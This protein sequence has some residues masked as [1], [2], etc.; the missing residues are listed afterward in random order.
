MGEMIGIRRV[1]DVSVKNVTAEQ[2]AE[3]RTKQGA[4]I[5][6]G[7]ERLE[8][9][10]CKADISFALEGK[11]YAIDVTVSDPLSQCYVQT[12]HHPTRG[13]EELPGAVLRAAEAAKYKSY[14][15]EVPKGLLEG[16][17][18]PVGVKVMPKC[19]P[20]SGITLIPLAALANGTLSASLI[21]FLQLLAK[22]IKKK[23][24]DSRDD[25]R[26]MRNMVATW[27]SDLSLAISREN[28]VARHS[29][30]VELE[31]DIKACHL[32]FA[33]S[34]DSEDDR[35]H[36]QDFKR[37]RVSASAAGLRYPRNGKGV[38]SEDV[39]GVSLDAPEGESDSQTEA[40]DLSDD[41]TSQQSEDG[42]EAGEWKRPKASKRRRFSEEL[43]SLSELKDDD[44]DEDGVM[45]SISLSPANF[46]NVV[47]AEHAVV[48]VS[49]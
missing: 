42:A 35:S 41:D 22:Q 45:P 17:E 37:R 12:G 29:M 4:N 16:G 23:L 48:K 11:Q 43:S 15:L 14:S 33:D 9:T 30:F 24:G 3:H 44:R 27:V 34:D 6:Y 46:R 1:P 28:A 36:V 2:L 25:R 38:D 5:P 32:E 13:S 40:S 49:Q 31:H 7:Y 18:L 10:D 39:D 26:K 19:V 21:G 47:N 20:K 8:T